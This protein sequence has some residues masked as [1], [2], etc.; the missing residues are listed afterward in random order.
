MAQSINNHSN[1]NSSIQIND[2]PK[3]T[4]F[5]DTEHA[6]NIN[7]DTYGFVIEKNNLTHS[8]TMIRGD[9]RKRPKLSTNPKVPVENLHVK[10]PKNSA[11]KRIKIDDIHDLNGINIK[12]DKNDPNKKTT[13]LFRWDGLNEEF[14]PRNDD[15]CLYTRM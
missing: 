10:L 11:L 7:L 6:C 8:I 14:S 4:F 1:H 13:L 9:D 2:F 3:I 12:I 5:S 15:Y